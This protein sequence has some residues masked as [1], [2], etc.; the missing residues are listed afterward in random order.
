[1]GAVEG[2]HRGPR[3]KVRP[4]WRGVLLTAV[5]FG[6]YPFWWHYRT[7]DELIAYM[8]QP[9]RAKLVWFSYIGLLVALVVFVITLALPAIWGRTDL[10]DKPQV[11]R[12]LA[13]E[14]LL[15]PLLF[16]VVAAQGTAIAYFL[17]QHRALYRQLKTVSWLAA[18][19]RFAALET[20]AY[21]VGQADELFL[22][23]ISLALFLFAYAF[24]QGAYNDFWRTMAFD[25]V[26]GPTRLLDGLP[27]GRTLLRADSACVACRGPLSFVGA[28]DA[29]VEERCASCGR[30]AVVRMPARSEDGSPPS[31]TTS[32][33][34]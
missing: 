10:S 34:A 25:P 19:L 33:A 27:A 16:L 13:Q 32:A 7:H 14:G 6:I 3:G 1:V 4:F 28:P 18:G 17:L 11:I 24:L 21:L 29:V 20:T 2:E 12:A 22:Q 8:G 15:R 30:L 9:N 5:T 31:D 26:E 23:F